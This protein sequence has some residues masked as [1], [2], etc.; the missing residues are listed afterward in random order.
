M[1]GKNNKI[2]KKIKGKNMNKKAMGFDVGAWAI[3]VI[4]LL[5]LAPIVLKVGV[6]V[7]GGTVSAVNNS[8]PAAAAEGTIVLNKLNYWWDFLTVS[9][10]FISMI[11]LFVSAYFIDTHPAFVVVYI[12]FAFVFMLIIP[13]ALTA[14]DQIYTQYSTVTPNLPYTDFVRTNFIGVVLMVFF[15]TGIIAYAKFKYIDT[16]F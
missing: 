15:L 2:D 9:A 6:A 13:N 12:V 10:M 4:L 8:D 3:L 5:I 16:G 11:A 7:I 14:V 1:G